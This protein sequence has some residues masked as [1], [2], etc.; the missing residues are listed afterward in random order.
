MKHLMVL[1]LAPLAFGQDY[2]HTSDECDVWNREAGFASSVAQHDA[3]AFAAFLHP[4]AL[5]NAA[6]NAP[7]RGATAVAKNWAGIIEGK[8]VIL[9]WLPQY[10]SIGGDPNIAISRG[11]FTMENT[12]REGKGRFSIGYFTSVWVREATGKPWLVLFDGGGAPPIAVEN[13]EAAATHMAQ[14]PKVCPG[15]VSQK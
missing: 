6:S 4:G 9:R 12:N 3:G 13:A 8:N 14:A 10:V 2:K 1:L 11:P 15:L 5:F 7:T